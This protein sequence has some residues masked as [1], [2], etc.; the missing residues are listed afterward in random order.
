MR[1]KRAEMQ[2]GT[3]ES[4]PASKVVSIGVPMN[5]DHSALSEDSQRGS[6]ISRRAFIG[7][8]TGSIVVIPAA[9]GGFLISPKFGSIAY[10]DETDNTSGGE[11]RLVIAKANQVGVTVFDMTQSV[12]KLISDAKVVIT[13]HA[14]KK[15]VTVTTD[16]KGVAL[17]DITDLAEAEG[18]K[19]QVPRYE[20][21]G[22]IE[23]TRQG[24]R[25]F[26]AGRIHFE[27][28]KGLPVPTRSIESGVPYPARVAFDD[29]DILYTNNEFAVAKGNVVK[30]TIDIEFENAGSGSMNVSLMSADNK[31]IVKTSVQPSG[32]KAKVAFQKLFLRAEHSEALPIGKGFF[33][34]YTQ[35]GKTYQCPISLV[36]AKAVP[37]GD[38]AQAKTGLTLSPFGAEAMG[39]G[40]SIK[41]PSGVAVIGGM[42]FKPYIP[43]FKNLEYSYDPFG[44]FRVAWKSGEYGN[45]WK[46]KDGKKTSD[47][48]MYSPRKTFEENRRKVW[49]D[50]G[51][52]FDKVWDKATKGDKFFQTAELAR[53]VKMNVSGQVML[54]GKW[55]DPSKLVRGI[56]RVS[57]TLALKYSLSWQM[58][59][60]YV[61]VL[62]EFEIGGTFTLGAGAACAAPSPFAFSKYI[63][64]YTNTGLDF[65]MAIIPS[66]SVGVGIRG[67][68]SVGAKVSATFTIFVGIFSPLKLPEGAE[69]NGISYP[70]VIGG[71]SWSIS[72]VIMLLGHTWVPHKW[73]PHKWPEAYNNWKGGWQPPFSGGTVTTQADE[74]TIDFM[75]MLTE[76]RMVTQDDLQATAEYSQ[77]SQPI[78][79]QSSSDSAENSLTTQ[80]ESTKKSAP[81]FETKEE[82][83]CINMANGASVRYRALSVVEKKDE[84]DS[85]KRL[86]ASSPYAVS[87]D[88]EKTDDPKKANDSEKAG[89]PKKTDETP[90]AVASSGELTTQAVSANQSG[91]DS[92]GDHKH[93]FN[94]P[95]AKVKTLASEQG[96]IPDSDIMLSYNVIGDARAKVVTVCGLPLL[97][98][99]ASCLVAPVYTTSRITPDH[100]DPRMR[101]CAESLSSNSNDF[102]S[103]V[104]IGRDNY[105]IEEGPNAS[106]RDPN[107][108]YDY[109]FAVYAENYKDEQIAMDTVRKKTVVHLFVIAGFRQNGD[110]TTLQDAAADQVLLYTQ[111]EFYRIVDTRTQQSKECGSKPVLFRMVSSNYYSSQYYPQ[112]SYKHHNF[113]CPHIFLVEDNVGNTTYR[114]LYM[115]FLD[116]A[117]ANDNR[118]N[119]FSVS[120]GDVD[121]CLGTMFY[122]IN[123]NTL[124]IPYIG[125]I[126]NNMGPILDYSVFEMTCTERMV[127]GWHIL[128]LRGNTTSHYIAVQTSACYYDQ[129]GSSLPAITA[130][131]Y[132]EPR[133]DRLRLVKW[134][135]HEGFLASVGGNVDEDNGSTMS[136]AKLQHVTISGYSGSGNQ[137]QLSFEDVGPDNFNVKSFDVDPTGQFIYYPATRRGTDGGPYTDEGA[138]KDEDV[139]THLI[140]ACKLRGGKFSEP[141]VFAEVVHPIDSLS[142]FSES[143][144]AMAFVS[145]H[146]TKAAEGKADL[147]LT[148]MPHVRSATVVQ[149]STVTPYAFPGEQAQFDVA[150]RNDGNVHLSGITANLCEKGAATS[151]KT[152]VTF[153]KDSLVESSW[154]P[155]DENGV[156]QN[157]ESDYSL[158]PGA[159]SVYRI[160]MTV[161]DGW[162]G[163]KTV[164]ITASDAIAASSGGLTTQADDDYDEWYIDYTTV[165]DTYPTDELLIPEGDE[166][167][168]DELDDAPV[169]VVEPPS[170]APSSDT[171]S[172]GASGEKRSAATSA[173]SAATAAAKTGD[174]LGGFGLA[175]AAVAAASAAFAVYSNRRAALERGE[176]PDDIIDVDPCDSDSGRSE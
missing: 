55:D 147:W 153:N 174:P 8:A 23:I 104:L 146:L 131:N 68:A 112:A 26:R 172:S 25:V 148:S 67:I 132:L 32:G 4:K 76:A 121:I 33:L 134:K 87:G 149:C 60:G 126:R 96:L 6:D 59:F 119:L 124:Y 143:S 133:T 78:S 85:N 70:H 81:R 12:R 155:A 99:I 51:D 175:A 18:K 65:T 75:S 72:I 105:E 144:S 90:V 123:T 86:V 46:N 176:E 11:T 120:K 89:D 117:T 63:W 168:S 27:G 58:M 83:A 93:N 31:E 102:K 1:S 40:I 173:R 159:T 92:Y 170:G 77:S 48:W 36:T 140:M 52:I 152:T 49:D 15:S 135:G 73:D 37:G 160:S 39:S 161:P 71:F 88:S 80:S 137:L 42:T 34:R 169:T 16:S 139:E 125:D 84:G 130:I 151:S 30:H 13:S 163:T 162:S 150:V 64:D 113:S 166:V 61:P 109:D 47:G 3:G 54:A 145:T 165:L 10:A 2:L 114:A 115:S 7:V 107:D 158:A 5:F 108:L 35:D 157:V 91:W 62:L 53:S 103:W 69:K 141:F 98:R 142:V 95:N 127:N 14:T 82:V 106:K 17:V 50:R 94:M 43:E 128:M 164:A 110:S 116:R 44:Y 129:S 122:Y 97:F 20:F 22:Q 21:D 56:F 74:D 66:V 100:Y 118:Q 79:T 9:A 136:G 41:I 138:T 24:Y 171:P 38:S 19:R 111:Q 29:W 57:A 154:N 45:S 156:L 101:V 28:A 167:D